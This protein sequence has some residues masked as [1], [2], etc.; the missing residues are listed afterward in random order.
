MDF[1]SALARPDLAPAPKSDIQIIG[2][3]V[4]CITMT[5]VWGVILSER[6]CVIFKKG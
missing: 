5:L 6:E 3:Y 4:L 2:V 1:Q